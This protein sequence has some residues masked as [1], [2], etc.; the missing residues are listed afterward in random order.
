MAADKD[1][2]GKLDVITTE[3][4]HLT[5]AQ[6]ETNVAFKKHLEAS[7]VI[8]DQVRDNTGFRT[9][10]RWL[11]GALVLLV[12]GRLIAIVII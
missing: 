9:T 7:V 4:K 5:K 8:R 12:S 10:A 11:I 6:T 3:I 1:L 2:H